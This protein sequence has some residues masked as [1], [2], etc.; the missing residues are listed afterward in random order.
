MTDHS[1]YPDAD[2]HLSTSH[3]LRADLAIE[4][5]TLLGLYHPDATRG[6]NQAAQSPVMDADN[7]LE[8]ISEWLA[9]IRERNE[10]TFQTYRKEVLRFVLW[11]ARQTPALRPSDMTTRHIREYMNF[12]ADPKPAELWV[13]PPVPRANLRWRPFT[14]PLSVASRRQARVILQAMY[15]KLQALG[16]FLSNPMVMTTVAEAGD[17]GDDGLWDHRTAS[18]N[19]MDAGRYLSPDEWAL[20][21]EALNAMPD[22]TST[23]LKAKERALF[24]M[25]FLHC[26]GARRSELASA[27]MGSITVNHRGLWFWNVLGKGKKVRKVP[28]TSECQKVIRR[29]RSFRGFGPVP[30]PDEDAPLVCGIRGASPETMGEPITD[31]SLYMIVR[32]VCEAAAARTDREDLADNLRR[33]S[34][35]WV[36]HTFATGSLKAGVSLLSVRDALGHGSIDT[37]S[38]YAHSKDDALHDD[39]ETALNTRSDKH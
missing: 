15:S 35:H 39:F 36:R 32:N 37:T 25:H 3:G 16:Y 18:R 30:S 34:I 20:I 31:K 10:H 38:I 29:W 2:N 8:A 1:S 26:T 24:V 9:N 12:L 6:A 13:G 22:N 4:L 14:G 5:S 27:R 19:A 28:I 7:D 11:G 33:A 23:R 21:I 17:V